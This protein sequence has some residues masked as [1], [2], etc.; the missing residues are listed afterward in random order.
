[1]HCRYFTISLS[2]SASLTVMAGNVQFSARHTDKERSQEQRA[3]S[4]AKLLSW[5][6]MSSCR[7]IL[8]TLQRKETLYRSIQNTDLQ[9]RKPGPQ[10]KDP[11]PLATGKKSTYWSKR[12]ACAR[13]QERG[14]PSALGELNYS[15]DLM[16]SRGWSRG[17]LG[18]PKGSH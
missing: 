7:L 16:G 12:S 6:R 5:L 8:S 1:L 4:H 10:L 3:M 17:G 11:Q 15:S 9:A 14:P 18:T 2:I 13:T